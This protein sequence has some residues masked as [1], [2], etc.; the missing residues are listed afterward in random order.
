MRALVIRAIDQQAANARRSH[1]SEGDFLLAGRFGHA[2]IEA[3]SERAGNQS[4]RETQEARGG[5]GNEAWQVCR[6]YRLLAAAR[7]RLIAAIRALPGVVIRSLP[8]RSTMYPSPMSR[9][10]CSAGIAAG[11]SKTEVLPTLSS[12]ANSSRVSIFDLE[13]IIRV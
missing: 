9:A 8:A 6:L 13:I 12:D 2:A 5:T 1:F 7:C 10:L 4:G 3:R 11:G